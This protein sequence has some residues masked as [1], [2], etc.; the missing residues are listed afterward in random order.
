LKPFILLIIIIIDLN[1]RIVVRLPI[2][3]FACNL[4]TFIFH[5]IYLTT[6]LRLLH[7]QA[8]L[9]LIIFLEECEPLVLLV[10][11][12]LVSVDPLNYLLLL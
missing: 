4:I 11:G 5:V 9:P 7:F 1:Y 8:L 3:P 2:L 6:L 10:R 12:V